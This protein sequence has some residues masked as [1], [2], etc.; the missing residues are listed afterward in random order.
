[1]FLRN[2]GNEHSIPMK[3]LLYSSLLIVGC[4][5]S[6]SAQTIVF[7]EDFETS[8]VTNF[9]NT[10]NSETQLAEG[11]SA[12]ATAS[13]G[14]TGDFNSTNVDFNSTQNA[15]DFLGANPES[16]CGGFYNAS[17][18][19][20]VQNFS[21]TADSLILKIR[22]FKSTTL[23]WGATQLEV[24]FDNGTT[25]DTLKDGFTTTD[26]W[27]ILAYKLPSSMHDAA[28]TITIKM[29]GG[30]GVGIDDFV[31]TS[32]LDASTSPELDQQ[33]LSIYPNPTA[34]IIAIESTNED[35]L[36]WEL[37]SLDGKVVLSSWGVNTKKTEIDLS[38]L[39]NG[40]YILSVETV[41]G[42]KT[43]HNISKK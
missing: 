42:V 30:E 6:V 26:S 37:H 19:S 21:A 10:W 36:A 12:C 5:F 32:Y 28:V 1:M 11:P 18:H 9:L 8:P 27:G 13:R 29:G 39:N 20:A 38:L 22:Y 16:P 34:D 25:T 40:N 23:N 41:S 43:S 3:K 2:E 17:L 33:N 7:A 35:I 14:N 4:N 15:S 24:I 31:I